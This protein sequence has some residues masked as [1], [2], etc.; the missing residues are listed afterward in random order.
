MLLR[1]PECGC[2]PCASLCDP[3][4][5]HRK[6]SFTWNPSDRTIA[7]GVE[8][9]KGGRR[10]RLT[11]L[12]PSRAVV[13]K[14]GNL[15]FLEPCGPLQACNG[16]ALPLPYNKYLCLDSYWFDF[17]GHFVVS[18]DKY[19]KVTLVTY[20]S[21]VLYYVIAAVV[22]CCQFLCRYLSFINTK[23][24]N[25]NVILRLSVSGWQLAVFPFILSTCWRTSWFIIKI[26]S[27]F[28]CEFIWH[29]DHYDLLKGTDTEFLS[30]VLRGK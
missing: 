1:V 20:K 28:L 25:R 17:L 24:W 2:A 26:G 12:P 16:T 23:S 15:N 18:T 4:A 14:S 8:G 21:V 10:I 6:L 13:M 27:L 29:V 5:K 22:T 11:T 9:G 19:R 3:A 7:P 30:A